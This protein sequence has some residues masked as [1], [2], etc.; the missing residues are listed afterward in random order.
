MTRALRLLAGAAL[1]ACAALSSC[2]LFVQSELDRQTQ[3]DAGCPDYPFSDGSPDSGFFL[4]TGVL[5]VSFAG[6]AAPPPGEVIPD[7]LD[8]TL[9]VRLAD[10]AVLVFGHPGSDSIPAA[11]SDAWPVGL[12]QGFQGG[13]CVEVL[14]A[15]YDSLHQ[16]TDWSLYNLFCGDPQ[17][18]A[19]STSGPPS[20]QAPAVGFLANPDGGAGQLAV[21]FGEAGAACTEDAAPPCFPP[22]GGSPGFS[23]G[24]RQLLGLL[25][26]GGAPAWLIA[27]EA[28]SPGVRLYDPTFKSVGGPVLP[29]A[30]RLAPLSSDAALALYLDGTTLRGQAID[31]AGRKLGVAAAF[32]LGTAGAQALQVTPVPGGKV[33]AVWRNAAGAVFTARADFSNSAAPALGPVAAVCG[34]AGAV[35]AAPLSDARV[36][37]LGPS[38][39]LHV[40]PVP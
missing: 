38:G 24:P 11:L 7:F 40:R 33:R 17:L 13:S 25:G 14:A 19:G 32:E 1:L 35:F 26:A 3:A 28:P 31:A 6:G 22:D 12:H 39:D 18:D 23:G 27:E 5:G 34:P 36:A 29:V 21:L 16:R 8:G 10:Q 2:T 9:I 30:A 4:H 15:Q 37:V 20:A